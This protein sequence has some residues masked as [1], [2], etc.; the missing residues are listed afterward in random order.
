[1]ISTITV[2][3]VNYTTAK[4]TVNNYDTSC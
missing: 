2:H 3:A 4:S 1:M